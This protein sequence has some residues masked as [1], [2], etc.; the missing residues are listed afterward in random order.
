MKYLVDTSALVR[1]LRG[2]EAP[3]WDELA[4]RGLLA[5]CEPVLTETLLLAETR[6][7]A[8]LEDYITGSYLPSW[9]RT[10]P[11]TW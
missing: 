1:I 8:E 10:V 5:I 3:V 6:K 11:G 2:Q 9:C 4:D 7:Y